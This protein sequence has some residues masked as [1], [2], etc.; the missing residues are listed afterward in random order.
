MDFANNHRIPRPQRFA[1][2]LLFAP[3]LE[4]L[5]NCNVDIE[6]IIRSIPTPLA[7]SIMEEQGGAAG[8]LFRKLE[9]G[10]DHWVKTTLATDIM[11]AH[12]DISTFE[13]D[14]RA[15]AMAKAGTKGSLSTRKLG[16]IN[17]P[18]G[19]LLHFQLHPKLGR[20]AVEPMELCGFY[21]R[22]LDGFA[23]STPEERDGEMVVMDRTM[24]EL[25]FLRRPIF[26]NFLDEAAGYMAVDWPT[27]TNPTV[28]DALTSNDQMRA[29]VA[30]T[31]MA[32][33]NNAGLNALIQRM[34]HQQRDSR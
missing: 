17:R 22:F 19:T 29:R 5:K 32:S 20:D 18:Y 26:E 30:A 12:G 15:M 9:E 27:G 25:V 34:L 7:I 2:A 33:G 3:I 21:V 10:A 4:Q 14:H 24:M 23:L 16:T 31:A 13:V 6:K 11:A 8:H 1:A 28:V